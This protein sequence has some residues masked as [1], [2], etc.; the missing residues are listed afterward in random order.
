MPRRKKVKQAPSE[1]YAARVA[2]GRV[3][4]SMS[5]PVET[6]AQLDAYAEMHGLTRSAA[7][8][9]LVEEGVDRE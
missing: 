2:R 4:V 5:L 9:R 8:V 1:A 6:I 3:P 7:V